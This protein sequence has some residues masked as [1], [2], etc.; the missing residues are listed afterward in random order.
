MPASDRKSRQLVAKLHEGAMGAVRD[1]GAIAMHYYGKE[2][3]V[4]NK[5]NDAGPVT[6]A[7]YA[8]DQYLK[9]KLSA[10]DRQAGWLS[11]ESEDNPRRLSRDRVWIV[12]PL[13][14]TRA[15][16]RSR[17]AFSISVALV[18]KGE[19][20]VGIVFNP[21]KNEMYD[22]IAGQGARLNGKR[23]MTRDRA[24]LEG[25]TVLA[26]R[27]LIASSRW[28]EPWPPVETRM[29]N[30]IAYRLALV[31]AGT[32]D[33]CIS[34]NPKSDWDIAAGDLIVREAGGVVSDCTGSEFTYNRE[35][36]LHPH[37]LAASRALHEQIL[38]RF[39]GFS[40]RDK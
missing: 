40:F 34:I 7:D 4:W 26:Y 35:S 13:D 38:Q 19:P 37:V 16:I 5:P 36:V 2:L 10:I 1:A 21:A 39:D 28:K 25:A 14:G 33:A 11:E 9:D 27:D 18:A 8:L 32:V 30:S 20:I 15:F 6:E 24:K 17:P 31:A 3:K 22:A 12:D 23:L 29:F